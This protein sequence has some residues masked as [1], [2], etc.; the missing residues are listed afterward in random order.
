MVV[1][2]AV[3]DDDVG[4]DHKELRKSRVTCGAGTL[5]VESA[6]RVAKRSTDLRIPPFGE[7]RTMW[8]HHRKFKGK[9]DRVSEVNQGNTC[10]PSELSFSNPTL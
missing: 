6:L 1:G 5:S 4:G 9:R 3:D 8:S 7:D 10:T 2:P